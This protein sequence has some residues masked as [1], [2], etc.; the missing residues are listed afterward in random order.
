MKKQEN[1]FLFLFLGAAKEKMRIDLD[2]STFS[3]STEKRNAVRG[4]DRGDYR[5]RLTARNAAGIVPASSK[6]PRFDVHCTCSALP[7]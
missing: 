6:N 5:R 7:R 1:W 4:Y 2:N 3:R